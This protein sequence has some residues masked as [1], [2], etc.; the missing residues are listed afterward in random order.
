MTK[1][2]E[3]NT[4]EIYF[5]ANVEAYCYRT[6][7]ESGMHGGGD[8]LDGDD[9]GAALRGLAK[10]APM[11]SIELSRDVQRTVDD[12]VGSITIVVLAA[13][14]EDEDDTLDAAS[15]DII[16][17][18]GIDPGYAMGARVLDADGEYIALD[19]PAD[20]VESGLMLAEI[21]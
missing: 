21:K 18:L 5:D 9:L 2:Y 15:R 10:V 7:S 6:I 12:A 16:D 1:R 3:P 8:V 19:I 14:Y 13:D 4:I 11:T 17:R 20:R